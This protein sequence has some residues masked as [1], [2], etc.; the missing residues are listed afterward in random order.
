MQTSYVVF[1]FREHVSL[2]Q[3]FSINPFRPSS[4]SSKV[5]MVA[6]DRGGISA[7]RTMKVD[8]LSDCQRAFG[9]LRSVSA[10]WG[11]HVQA[12]GSLRETKKINRET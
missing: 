9:L 11:R 4:K 7:F 6:A 1:Y 2:T 10:V 12:A 3:Y 5:A 8:Q